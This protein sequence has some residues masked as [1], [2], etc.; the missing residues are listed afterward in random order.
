MLAVCSLL[1]A[2]EALQTCRQALAPRLS[3]E[4]SLLRRLTHFRVIPSLLVETQEQEISPGLSTQTWLNPEGKKRG[5]TLRPCSPQAFLPQSG[6]RQAFDGGRTRSGRQAFLVSVTSLG[7]C[8]GLSFTV[9]EIK[10]R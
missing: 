6:L 9:Q 4:Q 3:F 5:A 10:A 8:K 2:P 1:Q 7:A